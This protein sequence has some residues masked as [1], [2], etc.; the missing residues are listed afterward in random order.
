MEAINFEHPAEARNKIFFDNLTP[1]YPNAKCKMETA[2]D[3]LTGRVLD[4]LSPI[5]K[6]QRG[7]MIVATPAPARPC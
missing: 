1:I 6:G 5:G 7:L 2:P 3:N 4:L